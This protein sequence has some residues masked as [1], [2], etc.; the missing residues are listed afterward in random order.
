[1]KKIIVLTLTTFCIIGYRAQVDEN[2][3]Y[4]NESKTKLEERIMLEKDTMVLSNVD[5]FRLKELMYNNEPIDLEFEGMKEFRDSDFSTSNKFKIPNKHLLNVIYFRFFSRITIKNGIK[6]LSIKNGKEIGIS[7][8]LFNHFRTGIEKTNK[9]ILSLEKKDL[10]K[11]DK[12]D[13]ENLRLY[14]IDL[15]NFSSQMYTNS[16]Y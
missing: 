14:L 15:E 12:I 3:S 16:K 7:E 11:F 2:L 5:T 8:S 1:M 9:G 6:Y 13:K 10:D 4:F